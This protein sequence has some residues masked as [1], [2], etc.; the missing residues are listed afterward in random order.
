MR[1]RKF[2]RPG[3]QETPGQAAPVEPRE[4]DGQHCEQRAQAVGRHEDGVVAQHGRQ[5]GRQPRRD[6]RADAERARRH[7]AEEGGQERSQDRLCYLDLSEVPSQK[8]VDARD[9]GGIARRTGEESGVPRG[10][11][12]PGIEDS[13]SAQD[14]GGRGVVASRHPDPGLAGGVQRGPEVGSVQQ[15]RDEGDGGDR[16][17]GEGQATPRGVPGAERAAEEEPHTPR[18]R[19]PRRHHL[20]CSKASI[21][22]EVPTV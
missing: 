7:E 22:T 4:G 19:T 14:R 16:E 17:R 1:S 3:P 13:V 5:G 11:P 20:S 18:V 6:A 21:G 9:E 2:G 12:H 8:G 15:E 10:R